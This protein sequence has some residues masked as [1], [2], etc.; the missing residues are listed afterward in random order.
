[1]GVTL[2]QIY[3]AAMDPEFRLERRLWEDTVDEDAQEARQAKTR[4]E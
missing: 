2:R 4:V 3:S 1:M